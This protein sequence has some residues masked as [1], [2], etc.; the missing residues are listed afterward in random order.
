MKRLC[1]LGCLL[2]LTV[3]A[4]ARSATPVPKESLE[5]LHADYEKLRNEE[6]P[7]SSKIQ[8]LTG[9]CLSFA[10]R[11]KEESLEAWGLVLDITRRTS[12]SKLESDREKAVK[13]LVKYH[14]DNPDLVPLI[15]GHLGRE[16]HAGALKSILK[17]TESDAVKSACVYSQIVAESRGMD[18]FH[19][20]GKDRQRLRDQLDEIRQQFGDL[21]ISEDKTFRELSDPLA[22]ELQYLYEGAD[23]PDIEGEDLDGIPF[24]LS[25]YRGK[26]I[27]LDF[28]GNW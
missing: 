27:F 10:S 9:R 3:P 5:K 18:L 14:A 4:I 19:A 28:W 21:E 6:N 26:V 2:W 7:S 16:E 22:F 1:V 8:K 25:D 13:G 23:A 17:K 12:S 15:L 20:S 11:N 24:K